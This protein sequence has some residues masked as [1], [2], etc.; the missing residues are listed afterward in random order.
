MV[1]L[2]EHGDDRLRE[3]ELALGGEVPPTRPG[4]PITMS[5][6][7]WSAPKPTGVGHAAV[8][9]RGEEADALRE[10][11]DG[12]VDLERELAGRR[13]D[14][15]ARGAAELAALFPPLVAGLHL[16]EALDER[17]TERDGL[18]GPPPLR[19]STSRPASTSGIVAAW[20]GNGVVAAELLEH[21]DDVLAEAEV[22]ERET[23]DLLRLDGLR[24]PGARGPRP[25]FTK[26]FFSAGSL[27]TI[28][29]RGPGRSSEERRA[30]ARSSNERRGRSSNPS[31]PDGHRTNLRRAGAVHL[32]RRAVVGV[33]R[34]PDARGGRRWNELAAGDGRSR[35]PDGHRRNDAFPGAVVF[36][37]TSP[38][39]VVEPTTRTV[40][41]GTRRAVVTSGIPARRAPAGCRTNAQGA[42]RGRDARRG[43]GGAPRV[44]SSGRNFPRPCRGAAPQTGRP[45]R[46]ALR[47]CGAL[48]A[49]G[50]GPSE[51]RRDRHGGARP[52]CRSAARARFSYSPQRRL[53]G[54]VV[55]RGVLGRWRMFFRFMADN[56]ER[57]MVGPWMSPTR[58]ARPHR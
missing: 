44:R 43:H 40:V 1:G 57:T 15:R 8:D 54:R 50:A 23:R 5:T 39:A 29:A 52:A 33:S 37:P 36:E 2:V 20:I 16:Q 10:R 46:G 12:A 35:A 6:P 28:A 47:T 56:S 38:R 7:R 45:S 51:R 24:G 14:E 58:P 3:V 11:L 32:A 17:C 19:P 4:V 22:A 13:E 26:G 34:R 27:V 25:R 53:L 42:R 55:G 21:A 9:L 18:A 41:V 48:G 31:G 30:G 49:S